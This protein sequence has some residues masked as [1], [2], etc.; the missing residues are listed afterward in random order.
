MRPIEE[1]GVSAYRIPYFTSISNFPFRVNVFYDH[2]T[3]AQHP[4]L[5][6]PKRSQHRL[7]YLEIEKKRDRQDTQAVRESGPERQYQK[8]G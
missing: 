3:L 4:V 8:D 1:R 7:E 6:C 2:C 5:S